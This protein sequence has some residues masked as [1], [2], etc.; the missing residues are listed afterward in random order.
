MRRTTDRDLLVTAIPSSC[1]CTSDVRKPY[2]PVS[3]RLLSHTSG[4][5]RIAMI[6][7]Y[8]GSEMENVDAMADP[9][10]DIFDI[11][12]IVDRSRDDAK[13]FSE[14]VRSQNEQILSA[15][16]GA[17]VDALSDIDNSDKG[18]GA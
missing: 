8:D 3:A 11:Y 1:C 18:G 12:A 6:P 15:R 16:T 13:N 14:K 7:T 4:E 5:D 2:Y 10:T 9:R 17:E